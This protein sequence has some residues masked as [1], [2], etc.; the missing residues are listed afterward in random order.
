MWFKNILVYEMLEDLKYDT[1]TLNDELLKRAIR[2][3]H[4]TE[5]ET[6]G[7]VS[8]FGEDSTVFAHS[9]NNC[10]LLKACREERLLPASVIQETLNKQIKEIEN[11]EARKVFKREKSRL[12]DDIIFDLLP[13]SF[14]RRVYTYLYLDLNNKWLVVDSSSRPVAEAVISLLREALGGLKLAMP[15]FDI[16]PS[17]LMTE[18][19]ES[20]NPPSHINIEDSCEIMEVLNGDGIIR[21]KRQDLGAEEI[22]SHL[23]TGKQVVKLGLT[24]HSKLS[25]ILEQDFAIKRVQ[26][27]DI[28]TEAR[29]DHNAETDAERIDADF[30]LMTAEFQELLKDLYKIL[31]TEKVNAE[32]NSE[33]VIEHEDA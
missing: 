9:V 4:K 30:V 29:K 22:Q 1:D 18:W 11:S 17:R 2:A 3:T 26:C 13:R 27:L 14:T 24:W 6:F 31:G 19:V 16:S 20:F 33:Q 12:K 23:K 25:F 32:N 8:P 10:I 21:C 7:W 28:I 15:E 5:K